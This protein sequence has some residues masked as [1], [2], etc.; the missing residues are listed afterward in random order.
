MDKKHN[1]KDESLYKDPRRSNNPEIIKDKVSSRRSLFT[2]LELYGYKVANKVHKFATLGLIF[3]IS[4]N[5][6]YGLYMYNAYWKLRRQDLR[7][8]NGI[9]D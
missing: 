6:I 3:F 4:G 8:E 1:S 7:K 2:S 9:Y 5:L